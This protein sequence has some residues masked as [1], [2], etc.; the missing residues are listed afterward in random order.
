ML[1]LFTPDGSNM[2]QND[3]GWLT[4]V[5]DDI[6]GVRGAP[7]GPG[8]HKGAPGGA[9]LLPTPKEVIKQ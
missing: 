1:E 8:G 6:P 2:T 5:Q 7:G 9:R 3:P 4:I